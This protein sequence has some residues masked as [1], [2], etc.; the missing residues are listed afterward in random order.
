VY[1]SKL[2]HNQDFV[3]KLDFLSIC[4]P[5]FAEVFN[6]SLKS[7]ISRFMKKYS[8]GALEH[9][10]GFVLFKNLLELIEE[11]PIKVLILLSCLLI[12]FQ[13]RLL[14]DEYDAPLNRVMMS[15][16]EKER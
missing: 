9:E 6:S 14:I 10:D 3:L 15:Q 2:S 11:Y 5:N 12:S 1:K 13:L 16:D 7:D 4:G 8:L